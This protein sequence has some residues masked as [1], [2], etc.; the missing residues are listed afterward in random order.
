MPP[1]ANTRTGPPFSRYAPQ[2]FL[3]LEGCP[4]LCLLC[5]SSSLPITV[6]VPT[7]S[8]SPNSSRK[9]IVSYVLRDV[10]VQKILIFVEAEKS[11]IDDIEEVF[12]DEFQEPGVGSVA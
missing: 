1:L 12:R 2:S 7:L 5:L 11:R 10:L 6:F 3:L 4:A 8:A 9:F